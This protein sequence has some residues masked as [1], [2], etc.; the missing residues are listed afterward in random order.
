MQMN[1][2]IFFQ[3]IIF[4]FIDFF[5]LKVTY[6]EHPLNSHRDHILEI[7]EDEYL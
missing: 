2:T 6:L 5:S 1:Y 4:N 3:L 7:E